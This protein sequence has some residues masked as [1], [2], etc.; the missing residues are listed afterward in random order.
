MQLICA[1]SLS[2]GARL[3]FTNRGTPERRHSFEVEGIT[4][5]MDSAL[6][7]HPLVDIPYTCLALDF[8]GHGFA[9][10]QSRHARLTSVPG[11]SLIAVNAVLHDTG[12]FKLIYHFEGPPEMAHWDEAT[13]SEANTQIIQATES[14][15][16][17]Y[18]KIRDVLLACDV[19]EDHGLLPLDVYS[20]T[21][22]NA[23]FDHDVYWSAWH[24]THYVHGPDAP[25]PAHWTSS[26]TPWLS[27]TIHIPMLDRSVDFQNRQMSPSIGRFEWA[28][29][30]NA[31][32]DDWDVRSAVRWA[33][34]IATT[35]MDERMVA[36]VS[37]RATLALAGD[38]EQFLKR[39]KSRTLGGVLDFL[40]AIRSRHEAL[41][42]VLTTIPPLFRDIVRRGHTY[43]EVAERRALVRE[44]AETLKLAVEAETKRSE[45]RF[46]KTV[47]IIALVFTGL[48]F[49]ST[50]TALV[51]YYDY[52]RA[53]FDDRARLQVLFWSLL[54]GVLAAI[55]L[56]HN[57]R[58]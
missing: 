17:I 9:E 10:F 54:P 49:V 5:T 50:I 41:R 33:L 48:S 37:H 46:T 47:N 14:E 45:E 21:D 2:L 20:K 34:D 42:R 56:L 13:L 53:I 1:K 3:S 23:A 19:I 58:R 30:F 18:R 28:V 44:D 35:P 55:L 4:F 29:D 38:L 36:D 7:T 25:L 27:G 16:P 26:A 31:D 12:V 40:V 8:S 24:S 39:N 52:Q 43:Y 11:I 22:P 15:G 6:R 51:D 57:T 32:F